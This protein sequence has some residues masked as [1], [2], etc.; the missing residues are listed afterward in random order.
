MAFMGW[1]GVTDTMTSH[2]AAQLEIPVLLHHIM[3]P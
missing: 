2:Q 1:D 3:I